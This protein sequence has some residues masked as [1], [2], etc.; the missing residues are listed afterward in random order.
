MSP[1]GI[2]P[3]LSS[4][5]AKRGEWKEITTICCCRIQ[6]VH[7]P[8]ATI[9]ES[10]A[11]IHVGDNNHLEFKGRLS[12]L[13][14]LAPL[15]II[16][17]GPSAIGEATLTKWSFSWKNQTIRIL[18]KF[19][20]TKVIH[21]ITVMRNTW[22]HFLAEYQ[23]FVN[24]ECSCYAS[25]QIDLRYG[26]SIRTMIWCPISLEAMA[27]LNK[28]YTAADVKGFYSESLAIKLPIFHKVK[29]SRW[30][31]L[32]TPYNRCKRD[33]LEA[34]CFVNLVPSSCLR[35]WF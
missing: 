15:I 2:G 5:W 14:A 3:W 33:I 20:C 27:K 7:D 6:E 21:L 10:A 35:V 23:T 29:P 32:K 26:D 17:N 8:W 12:G 19:T 28:G 24:G 30:S 13:S 31:E 22:R 25:A 9:M 16:R 18:R 11:D 1:K 4:K 34:I